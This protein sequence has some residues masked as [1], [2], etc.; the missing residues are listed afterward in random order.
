MIDFPHIAHALPG[1][2]FNKTKGTITTY[3][4]AV[5]RYDEISAGLQRY[6]TEQGAP[7]QP[8]KPE[9][10]VKVLVLEALRT[11]HETPKMIAEVS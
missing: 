1:Q 7:T 3:R 8:K 10:H 9:S 4:T 2:R 11:G 6:G 5:H